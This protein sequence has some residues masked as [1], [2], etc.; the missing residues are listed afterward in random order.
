MTISDDNSP[1]GLPEFI[2]A[3]LPEPVRAYIQFLEARLEK[4]AAIIE[5]LMTQV[6]ELEGRLAKNSSNSSKPPGSDGLKK[7]MN[8]LM[9][10]L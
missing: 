9:M 10:C 4:Q 1:Q 8:M 2:L 3:S 5:Q 7:S 6:R